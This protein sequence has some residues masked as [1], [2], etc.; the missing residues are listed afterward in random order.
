MLFAGYFR[1]L[2]HSILLNILDEAYIIGTGSSDSGSGDDPET[3]SS[4][5]RTSRHGPTVE[6]VD[7]NE[8]AMVPLVNQV[9]C[10]L[11]VCVQSYEMV[12]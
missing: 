9:R 3:E 5:H 8:T 7:D 11:Q 12:D 6:T 2:C 10:M 1:V 4:G